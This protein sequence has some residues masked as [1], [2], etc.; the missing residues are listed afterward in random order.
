[1]RVLLVNVDCEFNLAIRKMYTYYTKRGD[2]VAMQ[3]LHLPGYP[4]KKTVTIDGSFY[5]MVAISN[6]FEVNADKVIV[7][8]CDTVL[9]GGIGSRNSLEQLPQEI[10]E[11]DPY[12]YLDED[13]SWGFITRGCV[14]KCYFCK[15]PTHEGPLREYRTVEQVVRHKKVRFLDNNILAYDKHM[16]VFQKLIDM[17]VKVQFNQGLDFRRVTDENLDLLAK[18]KYIEH[19]IFAFDDWSYRELWEEKLKT[20][21]RH[22]KKRIC[23]YLY[24][25]PAMPLSDTV[26][27]IEWCRKHK[28]LPYIMRDAACYESEHKDFYTDLAAYCNQPAFFKKMSF[29]EFLLKRH[30]NKGRIAE[31]GRK[32][33]EACE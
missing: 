5:D 14:N 4:H 7:E 17:G 33:R 24:V 10:D 29:E 19:Y 9:Y 26:N 20:I 18:M 30:K 6:V 32:W 12:Y 27:R 1:M 2:V 28:C 23:L 21:R 3:D 11:C 15:V 22:I 31:S 25:N 16:E 8:G 13:M